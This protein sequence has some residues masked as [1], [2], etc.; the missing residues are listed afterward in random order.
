MV[1]LNPSP[2]DLGYVLPLQ[3]VLIS[4]KKPTDLDL[5]CL[6]LSVWIYI[7]NQDQKVWLPENQKWAWHLI[8]FSRTGVKMLVTTAAD[9]IIIFLEKIRFDISCKSSA[10]DQP[11]FPSKIIIEIKQNAVCYNIGWYYTILS[12][13]T[14]FSR[15]LQTSWLELRPLK[16]NKFW[17]LIT[18]AA[19]MTTDY[20]SCWRHYHFLEKIRLWHFM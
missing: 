12:I 8:G 9:N 1:S 2:D 10:D 17:Q 16:T 14:N 19:D 18:T 3:T 7:D 5:H 13:M 6:S 15:F 11:Y 20:N 4:L